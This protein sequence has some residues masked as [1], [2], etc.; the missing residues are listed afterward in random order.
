MCIQM[1]LQLGPLDGARNILDEY[2]KRTLFDGEEPVDSW[3]MMLILA[4]TVWQS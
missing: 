4:I 3:L 1:I 2:N